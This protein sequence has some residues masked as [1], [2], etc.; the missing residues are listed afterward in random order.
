MGEGGVFVI[1]SL[2]VLPGGGVCEGGVQVPVLCGFFAGG[3]A[4]T[5]GFG[6]RTGSAVT[7]CPLLPPFGGTLL[8]PLS[9]RLFLRSLAF[10]ASAASSGFIMHLNSAWRQRSAQPW[11]I[12]SGTLPTPHFV[13]QL[14]P[15]S[16]HCAAV[17]AFAGR[18]AA[19][20]DAIMGAAT[21]RR[22]LSAQQIFAS[23]S[24]FG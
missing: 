21:I 20:K 10:L 22:Q 16:M 13:R 2:T 24:S 17:A 6:G 12:S 15:A 23:N 5:G 4:P 9:L 14:L 1:G 8:P 19:M 7:S 18:F 11:T 3:C